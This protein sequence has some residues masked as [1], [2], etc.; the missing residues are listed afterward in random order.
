MPAKPFKYVIRLSATERQALEKLATA[1]E[2]APRLAN[3]ARMILWASEGITL[4]ETQRRLGCSQQIILNWRRAYLD[5][6]W[7]EGPDH[8]LCDRPRP[9]RPPMN[10]R[11][12]ATTAAESAEAL[13]DHAES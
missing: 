13:D 5:R 9:G 12:A 2:T 11:Q 8:A 10:A 1:P 6:R 7:Q 4:E 3:R